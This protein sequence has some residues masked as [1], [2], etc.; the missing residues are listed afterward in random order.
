[1]PDYSP[2]EPS[3]GQAF[4]LSRPLIADNFDSTT[5][6][7]ANDHVAVTDATVAS[8]GLHKYVTINQIQGADPAPTY[9]QSIIY[10]KQSGVT[11]NRVQE[12][13]WGREIEAG[14]FQVAPLTPLALA[15]FA[16][17][18]GA[19]AKNYNITSVTRSAVGDYTITFATTLVTGSYIPTISVQSG[20]PTF[21]VVASQSTTLLQIKTYTLAGAAVDPPNVSVSVWGF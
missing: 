1:M 10:T 14:T 21:S 4:R 12:L 18:T 11:P 9:P 7:I 3:S 20:S 5:D 16:G 6:A 17:A 8:R 15:R 13:Y 19:L 2:G